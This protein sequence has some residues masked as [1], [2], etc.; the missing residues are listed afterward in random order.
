MSTKFFILEKNNYGRDLDTNL[1]GCSILKYGNLVSSDIAIR[2]NIANIPNEEQWQQLE[3]FCENILVPL[4]KIFK[5]ENVKI[6]SAFRTPILSAIMGSSTSS[7]H[8]KG[9][10]I[11]FYIKD[12]DNAELFKYI[13]KNLVFH[14]MIAEYFPNGWIHVSYR[15]NSRAKT[16]KIKDKNH[17]NL[18]VNMEYF[19]EVY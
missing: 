9:Q 18:K 3:L 16:L 4:F 19:S 6:K 14:E 13:Q 8:C 10:A 17:N 7:N 5:E 2:H 12:V 15:D 1:P 11:D